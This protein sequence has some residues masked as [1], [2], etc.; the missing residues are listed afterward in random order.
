[1]H[2]AQMTEETPIYNVSNMV[3][4]SA[5]R[6]DKQKQGVQNYTSYLAHQ[7]RLISCS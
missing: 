1:M 2:A 3:E 5:Y 6:N 7:G 4:L